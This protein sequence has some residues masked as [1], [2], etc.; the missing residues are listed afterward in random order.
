MGL[1]DEGADAHENEDPPVDDRRR[2]C[3]GCLAVGLV[4]HTCGDLAAR[5]GVARF[6]S[7]VCRAYN[8]IMDEN[9]LLAW[10][11]GF[12]DGEGCIDVARHLIQ[13]Q[14]NER[15]PLDR[16]VEVLGGR[17]YGPYTRY[18]KQRPGELSKPYWVWK[19]SRKC[20]AIDVARRLMPLMTMKRTRLEQLAAQEI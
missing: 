5:C 9:A 14:Q 8:L 3:L 11:A 2:V 12:I 10:C 13:V 17:I 4:D 19:V 7:I 20:Q 6:D 18:R 15:E 16:L 1:G